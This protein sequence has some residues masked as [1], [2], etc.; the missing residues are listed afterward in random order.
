MF[1]RGFG[2]DGTEGLYARGFGVAASAS[3]GGTD[4]ANPLVATG[5]SFIKKGATFIT[6]PLRNIFRKD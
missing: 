2:T 6:N 1:A 3:G 4:P 5:V